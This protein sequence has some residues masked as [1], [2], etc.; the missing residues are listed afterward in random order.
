MLHISWV[1]LTI[2]WLKA[3]NLLQQQFRH[4]LQEMTIDTFD[5]NDTKIRSLKCSVQAVIG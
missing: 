4:A 5:A 2:L 1:L 3:L